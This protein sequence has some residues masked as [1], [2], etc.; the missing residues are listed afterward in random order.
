MS[1]SSVTSISTDWGDDPQAGA[2]HRHHHHDE[3]GGGG[4]GG[5]SA[6]SVRGGG[7]GVGKD[8][9]YYVYNSG[10]DELYEIPSQDPPGE[11]R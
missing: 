7:G 3:G 9:E 6:G 2:N 8:S 5:G 1:R 4:S 11:S 10:E